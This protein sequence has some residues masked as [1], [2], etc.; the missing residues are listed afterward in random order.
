[1]NKLT[2]ISQANKKKDMKN[3]GITSQTPKYYSMP[4]RLTALI[5][6]EQPS[7]IQ[8]DLWNFNNQ[9]STFSISIEPDKK[10]YEVGNNVRVRVLSTADCYVLILNWNTNGQPIQI[11]P[12]RYDSSNFAIRGKEYVYPSD[13]SN[14][15]FR[16]SGSGASDEKIKVI[17]FRN[18]F[19]ILKI[20]SLLSID[21]GSGSVFFTNYSGA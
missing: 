12:N 11:F 9:E 21:D 14:F 15:D 17:A 13:E 3:R 8:Q 6:Q 7:P 10:N 4:K 20:R 5:A 18:R 16:V 19:D 1:M 2:S